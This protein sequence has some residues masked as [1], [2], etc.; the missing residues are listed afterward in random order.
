MIIFIETIIAL[1]LAT[2]VYNS[3]GISKS[4]GLAILVVGFLVLP[5]TLKAMLILIG[6]AYFVIQT[7]VAE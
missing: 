4:F 5:A 3:S 1:F 2:L 7:A 6:I